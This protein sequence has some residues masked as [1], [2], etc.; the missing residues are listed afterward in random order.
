MILYSYSFEC[1]NR[2]KDTISF[3]FLYFYASHYVS[4]LYKKST[5]NI[6]ATNRLQINFLRILSFSR[7][8][9]ATGVVYI[10][11]RRENKPKII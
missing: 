5:Q 4:F 11:I 6:M 8:K 9:F 2:K 10:Y 3:C 7:H 1:M